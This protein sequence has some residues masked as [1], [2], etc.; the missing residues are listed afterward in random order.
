MAGNPPGGAQNW[1]LLAPIKEGLEEGK[2]AYG[3]MR[4]NYDAM[5]E[6]D[7]IGADRYFHCRANC[8]ASQRG[9]IGGAVATGMSELREIY[10]MVKGDGFTDQLRD[11][12][13]NRF[14]RRSPSEPNFK[15]CNASCER[16]APPALSEKYRK[17]P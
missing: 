17:V 9:P 3:D 2:A 7:T 12:V 8:E 14:G 4:R 10:G 5:I 16:F 11:Q 6:A 15:D 1:P 13:A